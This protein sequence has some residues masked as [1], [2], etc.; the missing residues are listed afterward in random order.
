MA[1]FKNRRERGKRDGRDRGSIAI[2]YFFET[3]YD[4]LKTKTTLYQFDIIFVSIKD[5]LIIF[6]AFVCMCVILHQFMHA[7]TYLAPL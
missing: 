6:M 1:H 2:C 7:D 4:L 3:F 5:V